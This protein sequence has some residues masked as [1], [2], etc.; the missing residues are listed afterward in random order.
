MGKRKHL[1]VKIGLVLG[2]SILVVSI[3]VGICSIQVSSAHI[4]DMI[5]ETLNSVE[6]EFEETIETRYSELKAGGK[7]IAANQSVINLVLSK[8]SNSLN[9]LIYQFKSQANVNEIII[10]DSSGTSITNNKSISNLDSVKNAL[11]GKENYFFESSPYFNFSLVC[12]FPLYNGSEIVGSLLLTY[13]LSNPELLNKI[14][15]KFDIECTIFED[16]TRINTT[17]GSEYLRTTLDNDVII[18]QIFNQKI[19]YEGNNTINGNKFLSVYN[20]L[21]DGTGEIQGILFF[22]KSS[23]K[24]NNTIFGII[25]WVVVNVSVFSACIIAFSIFFINYLLKP[26]KRVNLALED[27]S[28][29]DANLTKRIETKSNDEIGLVVEEF[30]TFLNKLQIILKDIKDSKNSLKTIGDDL[31]KS[32]MDVNTSVHS[33]SS[34]SSNITKS[35]NIQNESV[36]ET[37]GA[38][39]QITSNINSLEKMIEN[40]SAGITQA[41]AAIEEMIG[42]I[43]SVNKSVDFLVE[44]F[45]LLKDESENGIVK[46]R[47]VDK[48][49]KE[50]Q[51]KSLMLQETNSIINHIASE[52]NILAMNAAIEAAHAGD[53]GRGFSVVAAEI[54]KLAEDSAKQS[55]NV[56]DQLKEISKYIDTVNDSSTEVSQAF[57]K[58]NNNLNN[59]DQLITQIKSA[60]LEQNEGSKQVME[61]LRDMNDS[62]SEVRNASEEMSSGNSIIISEMTRLQNNAKDIDGN[63]DHMNASV[64]EI[65]TVKEVLDK[66]SKEIK[67]CISNIERQVD[68]FIV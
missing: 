62:A 40:Q 31:I 13:D 49:I 66:S 58:V 33:L 16:I 7:I 46:Q 17:L 42:N 52:T 12:S 10:T 63:L 14:K 6:K 34:N 39:N 61:A 45:K 19:K 23:E 54:R 68:K 55:K 50:I 9:T 20:P 5:V 22:A 28:N 24:I 8:D 18:D 32:V 48:Q 26:L 37:A 1:S 41:S 21:N 38:V 3:I 11:R 57:S 2:V 29:G 35:V 4:N 59:T 36:S 27:I 15:E 47:N 65:N 43:S 64:N 67:E 51:N 44:S 25:K 60:M 30:N 56:S 53:A